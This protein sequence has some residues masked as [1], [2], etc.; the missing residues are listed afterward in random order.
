MSQTFSKDRAQQR[1]V[2]QNGLL[3]LTV[4]VPQV[5]LIITAV[6]D[7]VIIASL[8]SMATNMSSLDGDDGSLAW[9]WWRRFPTKDKGG[10]AG[11]VHRGR[12]TSLCLCGGGG[13]GGG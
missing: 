8:A 6:D 13:G 11:E 9:V 3:F 5:Q 12:R 1:F 4:E 10:A 2:K 7:P